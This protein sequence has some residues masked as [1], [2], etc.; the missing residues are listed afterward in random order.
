ML[1][2]ESYRYYGRLRSP[3]ERDDLSFPYS[4]RFC[5]LQDVPCSLIQRPRHTTPSTTEDELGDCVH[6]GYTT[7]LLLSLSGKEVSILGRHY[8]GYVWVHFHCGLSVCYPSSGF[9]RELHV[10]SHDEHVPVATG[11]NGQ[12]PGWD[13]NPLVECYTRHTARVDISACFLESQL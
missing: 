12:F 13:F 9:L 8:H 11:M 3:N 2:L 10:L 7:L 4:H 1:S 5:A 6:F